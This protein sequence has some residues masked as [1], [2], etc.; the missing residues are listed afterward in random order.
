MSNAIIPNKET[1]DSTLQRIGLEM[2]IPIT[3]TIAQIQMVVVTHILLM[4]HALKCPFA[5]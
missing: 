5:E 2:A 4:S 3:L 1:T